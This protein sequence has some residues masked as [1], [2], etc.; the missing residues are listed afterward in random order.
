[1]H[2]FDKGT[3]RQT[4][5]RTERSW[6]IPCVGLY[7]L[8]SMYIYLCLCLIPILHCVKLLSNYELAVAP[9]KHKMQDRRWCVSVDALRAL[10]GLPTERQPQVP[11]FL[12]TDI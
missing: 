4:D 7:G 9:T 11:P 12:S 1:M 10:S 3:D 5:G 2:A 6:Q 8:R